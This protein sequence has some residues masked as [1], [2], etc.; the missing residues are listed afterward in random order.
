MGGPVLAAIVLS[1]LNLVSA[2]RPSHQQKTRAAVSEPELKA[3]GPLVLP[4]VGGPVALDGTSGEKAWENITPLPFIQMEP[5]AGAEPSERSEILLAYDDRYLYLAG[6]L[7]DR[8]PRKVLSNSKQR[9]SGN[10]SCEWFGIVIDSYNDKENALAFFTTPAGLRWDAA[11]FNDAQ[12][13]EPI[14][15][16]WNTFWDV[17]AVRNDEGW[18][19][20][21]RI[22]FSSLR[23]QEQDGRVVMGVI[24]WRQ[25][26]RKN[27]W[28]IF[29]VIPAQRGFWSKFKSSRAQEFVL[30]GLTGR[31]PVYA[32]PYLLGGL[33]RTAEL[34]AAGTEYIVRQMTDRQAGLDVKYGPSNNLTFDITVNPDFAQVE[35]DDQ[36]INL[37][38]FSLFFPEKRLF[39]QERSSIFDFTFET[40]EENRLFYSRRIGLQDGEKVGIYGGLRLVGR[41]GGW[42]LGFMDMHTDSAA[43]DRTGE[44]IGV[45]R[46]RRQVFNPYSYVGSMVTSRIGQDGSYNVAY[47]LDSV[48][49]VFGDD[50]LSLKWAQSFA[51]GKTNNPFSAEPSR[52]YINW[53]RRSLRG[54]GYGL[55][56]S[57]S[58]ADYEPG[59]GFQLR[60]NYT[61]WVGSVWHGWFPGEKS[62]LFDHILKFDAFLFVRNGDHLVETL[63]LAPSWRFDSKPGFAFSLTPSANYENVPAAFLLSERVE[64][65]KGTYRFLNLKAEFETPSRRPLNV[66]LAMNAG[67]F[68]DGRRLSISAAPR[69]SALADLELGAFYEF[70]RL[71]FPDR[72][73]RLNSHIARIRALYM[74]S[75]KFSTSAFLQYSSEARAVIGNIRFRYNPREGVDL[76]LVYDETLNTDRVRFFPVPPFSAG[77]TL[78][79]KYSY[80]FIL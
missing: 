6:R 75:T 29:P 1:A 31:R 7:Y 2:E 18:F 26:A 64:V 74:L 34:N 68:Y 41:V 32:T 62:W 63:I 50:Y 20:E 51:D 44:N 22:P 9:D 48:I 53:Q 73:Q 79:V 12:G 21:F 35:A 8:E 78:M 69:W 5:H 16:S 77:R 39:F 17:A 4:R 45:L 76:Y 15:T 49:R 27:E 30:E 52:Y 59:V 14:N 58:G 65:P 24:V 23:F 46:L 36:Q 57:G 40:S 67:S 66:K 61:R 10:P 70:D 60:D 11:V 54:L 38:R 28:V 47:G 56:F 33:G 42:D 3:G 13:E 80:T 72:S 25:I 55:S 19:A 43:S 37:T 71:S